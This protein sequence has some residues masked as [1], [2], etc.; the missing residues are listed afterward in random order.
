MRRATTG[1][2]RS[3]ARG[4][5]LQVV[6]LALSA[7]LMAC[8]GD[9]TADEQ[10]D[11]TTSDLKTAESALASCNAPI[12]ANV[13]WLASTRTGSHWC[14][15]CSYVSADVRNSATGQQLFN[16]WAGIDQITSQFY[17]GFCWGGTCWP[18]QTVRTGMSGN[19]YGYISVSLEGVVA[20]DL[21]GTRITVTPNWCGADANGTTTITGVGSNN[22]PY[23]V[24][25]TNTWYS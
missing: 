17:P 5:W 25:L 12:N 10:Q 16:Y 21:G 3:A 24:I 1:Q 14:P 11:P 2:L 22:V 8:G 4:T 23:T 20:F 13:D 18:S 15:G 19:W 6:G 7:T 9:L